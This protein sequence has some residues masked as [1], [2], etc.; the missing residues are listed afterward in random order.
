[1]TARIYTKDNLIMLLSPTLGFEKS[2]E[3]VTATIERLGVAPEAISVD[4]ALQVLDTLARG[5]GL[6][7]IAARLAKVRGR[8]NLVES[9]EEVSLPASSIDEPSVSK[10]PSPPGRTTSAE[11][12]IGPVRKPGP[13]TT[14]QQYLI[15]LLAPTL[16]MEKAGALIREAGGVK[17]RPNDEVSLEEACRILERLSAVDGIVGTASSFAKARLLLRV[18]KSAR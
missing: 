15:E 14:T 3:V 13:E 10:Q 5:T 6:I 2:N 16:G 9:A 7:A 11:F 1:L 4:E 17:A 18:P 12:R 8:F